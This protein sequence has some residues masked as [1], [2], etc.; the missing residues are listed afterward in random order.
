VDPG[1]ETG[2]PPPPP[3]EEGPESD[4]G[5][6]LRRNEEW[7]DRGR[8]E[9]AFVAEEHRLDPPGT[10]QQTLTS[11]SLQLALSALEWEIM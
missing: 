10:M 4:S 11:C 2:D 8:D 1:R 5:A 3:L 9:D 6:P 7:P